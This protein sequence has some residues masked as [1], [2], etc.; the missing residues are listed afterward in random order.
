MDRTRERHLQQ[1]RL[2]EYAI[3]TYLERIDAGAPDVMAA[4]RDDIYRAHPATARS[5]ASV[6]VAIARGGNVNTTRARYVFSRG[7]LVT[8]W[9]K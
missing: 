9:K 3:E 2:S 7:T 5:R 6:N 4:I 1:F 8:V